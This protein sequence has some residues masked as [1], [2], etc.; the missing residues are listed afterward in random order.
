MLRC[1]GHLAVFL[2]SW[3]GQTCPVLHCPILWDSVHFFVAIIIILPT[4]ITIII[5]IIM[6]CWISR[7][8]ICT[9]VLVGHVIARGSIVGLDLIWSYLGKFTR[10]QKK[11]RSLEITLYWSH[12]VLWVSTNANWTAQSIRFQY[13]NGLKGREKSGNHLMLCPESRPMQSWLDI[14][15]QI[16]VSADTSY[17]NPNLASSPVGCN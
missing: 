8:N 10:L 4:I 11:R 9:S 3:P 2:A 6:T 7:N 15:L 17:H 5:L 13:W 16:A 14:H 1:V 12:P